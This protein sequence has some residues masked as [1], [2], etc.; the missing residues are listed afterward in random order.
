M[1]K[2]PN[3]TQ[4]ACFDTAFH[5]TI[6]KVAYLY[7]LPYELYEQYRIRRYGFHGTSHAYVAERAAIILGRDPRQTNSI[8]CHLG[9]GCSIAAVREG[10]SIDTSMGLTPLEGLIMGT[11]CGDIDPA[12]AFYL[13]DHG[14]NLDALSELFNKQSGLL[15]V[16]G[17]SNDMRTL[18]KE[19]ADGNQRAELAIQMFCYRLKKYIGAYYAA[20]GELDA[21]VFTGG[22]GENAVSIRAETCAGLEALGIVLDAQR[23]QET[24]QQEGVI[25]APDSRV[26]VL[27]VPTDEEGVIADETYRLVA[28]P[29]VTGR[30]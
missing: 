6:P 8:T 10:C 25:S 29:A 15:G 7:A 16:S 12:I 21:L 30:G 27:V 20:L 9:N 4:V 11:R 3:A 5:A 2:L 28:E 13:S 24:V 14:F 17:Q 19:A 1:A 23:N 26:Q 22:V 18:T